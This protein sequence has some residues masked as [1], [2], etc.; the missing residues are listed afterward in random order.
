MQSMQHLLST[1]VDGEALDVVVVPKE[2]A[3]AAE[4]CIHVL[5][6]EHDAYAPRIVHH[7][8]PVPAQRPQYM[9]LPR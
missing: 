9:P 1:R 8:V 4:A 6:A 3:L 7:F 5:L 2:E